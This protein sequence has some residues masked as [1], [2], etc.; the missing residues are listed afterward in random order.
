MKKCPFC[1]EEIQDETV[2]CKHCG[3]DLQGGS[4]TPP[5]QQ[6]Q[7]V[8]PKKKTGCVAGGCAI[9][10]VVFG[11]VFVMSLCSMQTSVP[12]SS[13]P[14]PPQAPTGSQAHI[15]CQNFV[16]TRL[17]APSTA[18][19]AMF[20][21]AAQALPN[22]AFRVKSYVDSQNSF[23]A[24]IRTNYTCQVRYKAGNWADSNNWELE[25]LQIGGGS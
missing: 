6:I 12:T 20:D 22:R 13:K 5:P 9:M 2:V 16:K 18:D 23:G 10:L 19:F 24:Q 15:I 21:Y 14:T 7:I 25:N 17:K 3:R 8:E 1:A 11:V 4:E